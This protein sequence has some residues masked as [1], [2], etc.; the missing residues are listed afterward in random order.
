MTAAPNH[1]GWLATL[2]L[3]SIPGIAV[4]GPG[5]A[6][7]PVAVVAGQ[8]VYDDE[9]TPQLSSQLH[10]LRVQ[11][12]DLK[13][14][15]LDD[16]LR[17]RVLEAEARKRGVTPETLL[18]EQVDFRIA[19]PND[20]ELEAYY[21]GQRDRQS[22]PFAEVKDKLRQSLIAAKVQYAR[23]DFMQTLR[24]KTA[25][26]VLLRA[27]KI[28]VAS[29]PGRLRGNAKA[30][31]NIVE[32]SDF[33]C[34]FCQRIQ[35]VLHEVLSRYAGRVSLGYRDFPLQSIHPRAQEAAEAARC[36][37]DQGKFWEYHD[38]LFANPSMLDASGLAQHARALR[39]DE[40]KFQACLAGGLHRQEV[41][42]DLQEGLRIG[43]EGTPTFYVNGTLVENPSLDSFSKI[44]A[45]ELAIAARSGRP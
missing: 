34:P 33:Q 45:D 44:I 7:I 40:A 29:D 17:L 23:R 3:A 9:L 31:V 10:Q 2:L 13:R 22:A 16:L 42:R 15:A 27:P 6:R 5:D 4:C 39:L 38:L 14:K 1:R 21:L 8:E 11:E 37:G 43:V 25:V 30:P 20:A 19:E 36:A 32:F 26:T 12:Y 28:E 41:D 18:R 24:D 35:G